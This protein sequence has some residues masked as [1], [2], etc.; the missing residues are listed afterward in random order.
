MPTRLNLPSGTPV[1]S[2]SQY[3]YIGDLFNG[4][5]VTGG[6]ATSLYGGSN[7]LP[8]LDPEGPVT[9]G[10]A[11][12]GASGG[13][14]GILGTGITWGDLL[15]AAGE[16]APY[17]LGGAATIQ[18]ISNQNAAND[19][20]QEA[21][22]AAREDYA[23]RA[24]LRTRALALLTGAMPTPPDLSALRNT[25]N[26]YAAGV[27]VNLPR[28]PVGSLPSVP[29]T[30]PGTGSPLGP[31]TAIGDGLQHIQDQYGG[32]LDW[33]DYFGSSPGGTGT[34]AAPG[35]TT[36]HHRDRTPVLPTPP[37]AGLP[38]PQRPGRRGVR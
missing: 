5:P 18:A 15:H 38:T 31:G 20:R 27:A 3:D 6:G 24:P 35:T 26:P 33:H 4:S 28:V 1:V 17:V 30:T 25:G 11:T 32:S 29:D 7:Q 10:G 13:G 36:T 16:A 23:S 37:V 12:S 19:L 2:G 22:N 34:S 21:L 9:Y 8:V 14:N